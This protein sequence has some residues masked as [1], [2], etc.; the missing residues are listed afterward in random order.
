MLVLLWLRFFS[1]VFRLL[2]MPDLFAQNVNIMHNI[3][4]TTEQKKN[5]KETMNS[6]ILRTLRDSHLHCKCF[7]MK[8][9]IYILSSC[10]IACIIS[11]MLEM[12]LLAAESKHISLD[13]VYTHLI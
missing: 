11:L 8:N 10:C 6:E 7:Q 13:S 2:H 4:S 5:K 1:L 12:L 3:T 9:G